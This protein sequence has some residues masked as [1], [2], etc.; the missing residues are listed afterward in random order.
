MVETIKGTIDRIIYHNSDNLYTIADVDVNDILITIVGYFENLKPGIEIE[1]EG[2]YINHIKYGEQFKVEKLEIVIPTDTDSIYNYL[3]SGMVGGIGPK[4]AKE[5]V[6]HFGDKTLEILEKD[7][8]R[9]SEV[10]GIGKKTALLVGLEYKNQGNMRDIV[11][12]LS[13]YNIK[14]NYA[15][16][17]Y[18]EYKGDTLNIIQTNPYALIDDVYGIGFKRAD[19]I[20]MSVGIEMESPYRIISGIKYTLSSCYRDGNTYILKDELEEKVAKILGVNKDIISHNLANLFLDDSV[21]LE[22]TEDEERC[23]LKELYECEIES[24]KNLMSLISY[25]EKDNEE[26]D[27]DKLIKKYEEI[28]KINLDKTQKEAV[29]SAIKSKVSIITGGPGTGKTTIINAIIYILGSIGKK[30]TLTAPTGRA[31]KRMSESTKSEAKTI[32]RLLEYEYTLEDEHFLSFG[33]NEDNTIESE[34]II[35]DEMSMVDISLFDAF[36]KAV[37]PKTSLLFVGDIDQLP[38]VGAGNVLSD[39]ISSEIFPVTKLDTI[40]RQDKESLIITNAH[41]INKGKMP[42][43]KKEAD[44]FYFIN[45]ITQEKI[46]RNILN[47]VYNYKNTPLKKYDLLKDFQIIS[48]LKKGLAGVSE[49][50]KSVQDILNPA[51][52][53]KNEIQHGSTT[54]RENDKVMQIK[55][56][57]QIKWTDINTLKKGEGVFNGDMGIIKKIDKEKQ[58]LEIIF[59]DEKRVIYPK[60]QMEEL[61]LSYAITVHKSQGSE[62]KAIIIPIFSGYSGFLNRNLLYT[63][64]TR[65]K[66]MVILIGEV[67]GLKSMIKSVQKNKRK[68]TLA[69]RLHDFL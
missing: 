56:N 22:V 8:M 20:A 19:Q 28:N 36:L 47:I 61:N 4:K 14:P 40:Y 32:H 50:N 30:Y 42:I 67:N 1:A 62:F 26:I 5:I 31:A 69:K 57:Y 2:E 43:L 21:I 38:S 55:N 60:E 46:K 16:K 58:T 53:A 15:K 33:K 29:I 13:K 54:F 51:H 52:N 68:T 66:E 6:E 10:K 39:L 34:Y 65:A 48:P 23:F 3:K 63:A 44:D 11:L 17:L 41:R 35:I 25:N 24:A 37:K 9:L 64:V 18:D 12:K 45:T 49:L 7:P 27:F 59:D